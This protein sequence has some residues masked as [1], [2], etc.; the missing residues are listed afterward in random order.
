M[1]GEMNLEDEKNKERLGDEMAREHVMAMGQG[2]K[3]MM[4]QQEGGE[5]TKRGEKGFR[6][7]NSESGKRMHHLKVLS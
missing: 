3:E 4:R 6:D 5:R 2:E 1:V 7:L